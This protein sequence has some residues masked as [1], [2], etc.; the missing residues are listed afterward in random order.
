[1]R[2][3]LAAIPLLVA[4]TL[5]IVPPRVV[6]ILLRHL[7]QHWLLVTRLGRLAAPA[8]V[9]HRSSV[10]AAAEVLGWRKQ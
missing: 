6:A 10:P 7:R 5:A 4:T 2:W 9:A 3:S 8:I 1:M